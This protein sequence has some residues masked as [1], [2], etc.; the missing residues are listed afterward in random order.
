MLV[1]SIVN[2]SKYCDL[3]YVY[4]KFVLNIIVVLDKYKFVVG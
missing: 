2:V 4:K 1:Y 3:G